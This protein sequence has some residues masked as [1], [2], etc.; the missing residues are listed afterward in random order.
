MKVSEV[1]ISWVKNGDL[2]IDAEYHLSEGPA[3]QRLLQSAPIKTKPLKQVCKDIFKGQIFKRVYVT[4]SYGVRF[5]S[6]SDMVKSDLDTGKYIS[7]KYTS[8]LKSLFIEPGTIL[9][10]RSGTLGVTVFTNKSFKGLLGSDDLIRIL[11][12]NEQVP[13]GYL[14]AFLATKFGY[15][16]LIQSSYGG[17]IKHIEP[18]HIEKLPVPMIRKA[19][20]NKSNEL[21]LEVAKQREEAN[22]LLSEVHQIF[23]DNILKKKLTP[24]KKVSSI[25]HRQLCGFQARLDATYYLKL[26][27]IEENFKKGISTVPL[28]DLVKEPMYIGQRGKRVYVK[29]GIKFLSTTDISEL[30][31]LLKE[32]YLSL[33]TFGLKTLIVRKDWIL[34]ARSG[35][36]ILGSAFLVDASYEN[37]AVNEHSIRIIIDSKKISPY[38]IF[39]FLS[40]PFGREYLRSGIYGSAILTINEDFLDRVQI[41]VLPEDITKLVVKKIARFQKLREQAN[42]LEKEAITIVEKEIESWQK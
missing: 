25:D 27:F 39:G 41:P 6:A 30:N 26:S 9:L 5:I 13:A 17:V 31:P 24:S 14:Y 11:P 18:H 28:K 32:K 4:S 37:C 22:E 10:S 42:F 12:D 38:Y 23:S 40:S 35:Q 16:L 36:D 21:I 3:T 20:Q 33:Y 15:S 19:I 8:Q 2:R 29:K 34:V 7:R 1:E